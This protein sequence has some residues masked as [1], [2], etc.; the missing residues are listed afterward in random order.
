MVHYA[1]SQM[2]DFKIHGI[3]IIGYDPIRQAYFG[4]FFDNQGSVGSE[5][6]RLVGDTWIWYGENVMGVNYHRCKAVLQ[7][8][9]LII[10]RHEYSDDKVVWN[11]C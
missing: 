9:H 3:E 11:H 5:E 7:K 4:L 6:L 1:D 8:Q 2:G 10:A